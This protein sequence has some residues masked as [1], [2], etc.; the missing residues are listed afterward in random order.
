MTCT[1]WY[2]YLYRATVGNLASLLYMLLFSCECICISPQ[3]WR[4]TC[5]HALFTLSHLISTGAS[6]WL[7]WFFSAR[8]GWRDPLPT[9]AQWQLHQG[10][11][12]RRQRRL[13]LQPQTLAQGPGTEGQ[14]PEGNT[15]VS[16]R[17][18]NTQ[19][20]VCQSR[21]ATILFSNS[22]SNYLCF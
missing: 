13:R 1:V 20:S 15:A 19:V 12:R 16:H 17:D 22:F 9:Y 11:G 6:G 4:V 3:V 7:E 8:E 5:V 18:D 21:A 2:R 14:L 10:H